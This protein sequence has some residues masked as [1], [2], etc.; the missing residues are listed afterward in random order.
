MNF[1]KFPG[2]TFFYRKRPLA[3]FVE[4][5]EKHSCR[6]DLKNIKYCHKNEIPRPETINKTEV[7]WYLF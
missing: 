2:T 6:S 7:Q 5:V 1:V 4:I 3:A